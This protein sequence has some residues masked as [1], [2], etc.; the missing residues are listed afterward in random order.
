[1]KILKLSFKI[2]NYLSALILATMLLG[3][4]SMA[5]ESCL[6]LERVGQE[7]IVKGRF[8]HCKKGDIIS[9]FAM[10]LKEAKHTPSL[11]NVDYFSMRANEI[12][13][14]CSFEHPIV[15]IGETELENTRIKWFNCVFIGKERKTRFEPSVQKKL[16]EI[17]NK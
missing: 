11:H 10:S 15:F 9:V 5:S 7:D 8:T 14:V 12:G 6:G 13:S 16:D 17:S 3:N 1:M 2:N 4:D